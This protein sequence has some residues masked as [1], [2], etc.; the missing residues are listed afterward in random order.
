[1]KAFAFVLLTLASAQAFAW[2]NLGHR[3]VGEIAS[4]QLS[5][6][7]KR[8]V[9]VLSNGESLAQQ[10]TW[11]DEVR[12]DDAFKWLTPYHFVSIDTPTF[13]MTKHDP[14]ATDAITGI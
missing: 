12:S 10:A 8:A 2:G 7:A 4:M 3:A 14:E 11:P 6:H 13:D 5:P 1:M 9:L